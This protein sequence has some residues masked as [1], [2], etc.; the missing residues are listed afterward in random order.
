M[1]EARV[2]L[3]D[4]ELSILRDYGRALS[5]LGFDVTK[6]KNRSE[7]LRRLENAS[8]DVVVTDL[9]MPA[10]SG[11]ELIQK[12]RTLAPQLPLIVMLSEMDN[13]LA[14]AAAERGA[15]QSLVKP[16][17]GALL[18]RTVRN[19]LRLRHQRRVG[20]PDPL[21]L[22]K[23][24]AGPVTMNATDAKNKMGQMLDTVMLG[25]VVLITK[26]DAARAAVIPITEYERFSRAAEARL[27]VLSD[28]FD[29][30]LESMQTPRARA[31]MR[32]AF[33]AS[34][35]QLANAAVEFARKRA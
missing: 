27:N 7:A 33:E 11:L 12:V 34:P 23:D 19:A 6:A 8:F 18:G 30:L 20:A 26:Y 21:N 1:A 16:I 17:N 28:E 14:V 24:L 22:G 5:G 31:G 2:L 3:V 4:D 15:M 10:M 9:L 25:H 29:A 13:E 32:A 35:K